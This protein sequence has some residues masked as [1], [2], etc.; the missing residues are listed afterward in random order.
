LKKSARERK[1]K[2]EG[3]YLVSCTTEM[4]LPHLERER[5]GKE[6]Q[7]RWIESEREIQEKKSWITLIFAS[8]TSVSM[9]GT[10]DLFFAACRAFYGNSNVPSGALS[11]MVFM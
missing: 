9:T 6:R 8:L 1:G 5:G 11:E 10:Y 7:R 4:C 2:R 3:G